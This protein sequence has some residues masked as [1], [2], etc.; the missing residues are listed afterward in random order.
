MEGESSLYFKQCTMIEQHQTT[1]AGRERSLV[2]HRLM[3][4]ITLLKQLSL[5]VLLVFISGACM[6][7]HSDEPA[8]QPVPTVSPQQPLTVLRLGDASLRIEWAC[9]PEAQQRGLMFRETMPEDQGML[10][11]FNEEQTL[12]FWMKNTSLP[13]SIAYINAAGEIVDIQKLKPFDETPRPSSHP[14]QYALEVNQGWFERH[15]IQVGQRILLDNLCE[16]TG[17]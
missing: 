14:A 12:S 11:V 6:L 8:A 1:G 15:Q 5:G 4:K 13:L 7:V 9:T 17:R 10:F 2:Y 16:N 3:K